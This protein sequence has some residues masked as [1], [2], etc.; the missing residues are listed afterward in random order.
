MRDWD[1]QQRVHVLINKP[2]C[3]YHGKVREQSLTSRVALDTEDL[4]ICASTAVC[5]MQAC[6]GL[7]C[8]YRLIAEVTLHGGSESVSSS[9]NCSAHGRG[10]RI[11]HVKV[12][13]PGSQWHTRTW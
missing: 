9:C 5:A 7:M 1:Q 6:G 8:E 2:E 13:V 10:Q 4:Q 12:T 11:R 3:I